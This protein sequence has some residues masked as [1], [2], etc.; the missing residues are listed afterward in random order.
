MFFGWTKSSLVGSG[1]EDVVTGNDGSYEL[2]V[3]VKVTKAGT[4]VGLVPKFI[5]EDLGESQG[6]VD[7]TFRECD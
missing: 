7:V 2:K 5:S 3:L 1:R 4:T 6:R